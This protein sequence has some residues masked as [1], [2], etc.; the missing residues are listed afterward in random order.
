MVYIS[1]IWVQ[2]VDMNDCDM[3]SIY[4]IEAIDRDDAVRQAKELAA[5]AVK[6]SYYVDQAFEVSISVASLPPTIPNGS[7]HLLSVDDDDESYVVR[8]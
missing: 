5:N 6:G 3:N 4:A 1:H 7:V 8:K 2:A